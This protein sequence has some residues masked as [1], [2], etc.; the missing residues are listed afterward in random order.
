ML[1]HRALFLCLALCGCG[2]VIESPV[3][4]SPVDLS[5]QPGQPGQPGQSTPAPRQTTPHVNGL[6]A[7]LL[8]CGWS[9][10]AAVDAGRAVNGA[11]DSIHELIK[12]G[13]AQ[14]ALARTLA[15]ALFANNPDVFD[16]EP[17]TLT[18]VR[19]GLGI[20]GT[21]LPFSQVAPGVW[22][23]N[24]AATGANGVVFEARFHH[25]KLGLVTPDPFV[26][27]S[28]LQGVKL[29]YD[30]T[31]AQMKAQPSKANTY[32]FTYDAL[33]PLGATLI[34]PRGKLPNPIVLKLSLLDLVDASDAV[35]TPVLFGPFSRL[36]DLDMSGRVRFDASTANGSKVRYDAGTPRAPL[37]TAAQ[38][39]LVNFHLLGVQVTQGSA[40]LDLGAGP[41]G[42]SGTWNGALQGDVKGR[43]SS[44]GR[45]ADV[46][47]AYHGKGWPSV[48]ATCD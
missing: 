13:G 4:A 8:G 22:R 20:Y 43:V 47:L 48:T 41:L 26:L 3:P 38:T 18:A 6:E 32:T 42:F 19:Q 12:C 36:L 21:S 17:E 30:L 31:F 5:A 10:Q 14:V 37:R 23:M 11:G 35:G 29:S 34:G 27:A 24:A 28:Y 46:L 2:I 9:T 33:G 45:A 1:S 7:R 16:F 44:G 15:F 25:K 40:V 39:S